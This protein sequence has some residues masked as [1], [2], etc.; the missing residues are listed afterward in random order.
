MTAGGISGVVEENGKY[1]VILCVNDYDEAATQER[2][3]W[4]VRQRKNET[5][6]NAYQEFKT[7]LFVNGRRRALG[8]NPYFGQSS[9]IR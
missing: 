6:Y 7:E 8:G 5:F 1:Y 3:E 4:M 9:G 2:K